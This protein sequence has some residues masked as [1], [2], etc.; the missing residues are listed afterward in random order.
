MPNLISSLIVFVGRG[1]PLLVRAFLSI[2]ASVRCP[3]CQEQRSDAG[4]DDL[5]DAGSKPFRGALE[6]LVVLFLRS[7]SLPASASEMEP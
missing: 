4:S 5:A 7:Q 3:R 2:F 6:H 1:G